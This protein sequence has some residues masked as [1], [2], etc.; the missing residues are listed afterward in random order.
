[1]ERRRIPDCKRTAAR[2]LENRAAVTFET[3]FRWRYSA[4]DLLH[5]LGFGQFIVS[6][7]LIGQ[8]TMDLFFDRK[9]QLR[10]FRL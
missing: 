8:Q 1:M 9:L 10:Q 6:F 5:F 7:L 4:A 3:H 2:F